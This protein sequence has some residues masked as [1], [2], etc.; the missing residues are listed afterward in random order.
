MAATG[1][2]SSSEPNLQN[3]PARGEMGRRF[4]QAFIPEAGHLFLAADYSQ[5]ELRVLAQLSQD[6]ALIESFRQDLDIHAETARRVFGEGSTVPAEE[7]R[8]RAKIINFSMIYGASA[9]SLARELETSNAEAQDFIDRYYEKHPKVREFLEAKVEEAKKTG[10]ASTLF[11]RRRQVPELQLKDKNVQLAGRRIALN[12][13][14]QGTAAD[15]M[16]MAMIEVWRALREQALGARLI[17]QVH[18]ELV[19]E[20]PDKETSPVEALVREKMENIYRLEAPLKVRLSWGIN[21]A[22]VK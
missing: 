14:I 3:I 7:Q 19:F 16:K 15:L 5:I 12:M 6:P 22:E 17:L 10:Y 1:R 13:P 9:F 4:R 18:D 20:V 2:L 8:R 11:G 21:W